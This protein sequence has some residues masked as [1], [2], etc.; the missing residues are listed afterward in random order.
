MSK[1][2]KRYLQEFAK[3]DPAKQDRQL[4]IMFRW[5]LK[6]IQSPKQSGGGSVKRRRPR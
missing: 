2:K 1:R 4:A 5:L 3:F 6:I